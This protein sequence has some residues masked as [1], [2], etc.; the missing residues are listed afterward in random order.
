MTRHR[1]SASLRIDA[2]AR[3]LYSIIADYRYGHPQILPR[4]PFVSM[5][6][7][8][9]GFGAGTEI[10]LA[11]QIMGKVHR[12]HGV[13]SEPEAG[14]VIAERYD[15]TGLITTFIVDPL[16]GGRR[17]DVTISTDADVGR[18]LFGLVGRWMATCML[19]P[20][21]AKELNKLAAV[22]AT[23]PS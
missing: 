10:D 23:L 12:Y 18:G 19:K 4:P 8:N 17:A 20:V 21:Y 22:A 6:V 16:D 15:G 7:T 9:G 3:R 11:M 2:P 1:I 5:A 13:V 14:R